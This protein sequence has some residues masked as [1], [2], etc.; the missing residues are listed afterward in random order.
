MDRKVYITRPIAEE[1]IALVQAVAEIALWPEPEAPP[2]YDVLR[3]EVRDAEGLL[4]LL[5]DRIDADLI[6]AA[7]RLRVI[8]NMAV[9]YDNIAVAAA[10]ARGIMVCNTPGVLTQTTADLAWALIMAAARRIAEAERHLRAGKW[11][12]WSP[13][14][15][16]GQDVHGATLGIIGFGRIG[17]AV[18]RR[19][20]GFGMRILYADTEPRPEAEQALGAERAELAELLRQSDFVTIHTPLTPETRHLIGPAELALMKPTAVL[21]NTARG[22]VV[23][24]SALAAALRQGRIFAAGLDVFETEPL[25]MDSPLLGLDNV[26]LLPHIGS[27][28]VATRAR[29]ARMAAENVVAA[30][31]GRRPPYLVNT[32]VLR[33]C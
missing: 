29:M 15:M 2:P 32:E 24:E 1:A 21:V 20:G 25:P 9:G 23:E 10:T 33:S 16:L 14:L 11:R 19:A 4:C 6:G 18:A 8:S 30:L 13:Q 31:E 17:Q 22:P 3:R 27:A 12:S 5:T 28:S 26:V 7:E